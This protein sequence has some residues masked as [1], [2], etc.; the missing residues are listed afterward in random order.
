MKNKLENDQS[1]EISLRVE[2]EEIVF[3][4][5]PSRYVF[6]S[7]GD[8]RVSAGDVALGERKEIGEFRVIYVDLISAINENVPIFDVL[9]CHS[10][11]A[12]HYWELFNDDMD[13]TF[14][15]PVIAAADLEDATWN[16]N[17]LILDRLTIEPNY[18]GRG[19]GLD[20]LKLLMHRY[21][22]GC[23]LIAMKPFPLQ[24]Q[25]AFD[26]SVL[27]QEQKAKYG[28]AGSALNSQQATKKLHKYYA[29]LGF[30][31]AR[32]TNFMVLDPN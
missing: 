2:E 7:N 29:K 9:D 11:S 32:K 15:L 23:G 31:L 30:K 16:P 14:S 27:L 24:F 21:R 26:D 22:L 1:F 12:A 13:G 3:S 25:G 17:L 6:V 19:F 8:I 10:E 5:E 18:R 20:A 4:D 28:L